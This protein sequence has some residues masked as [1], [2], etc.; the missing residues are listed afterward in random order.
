MTIFLVVIIPILSFLSNVIEKFIENIPAI[1]I[2]QSLH[3][4]IIMPVWIVDYVSGSKYLYY[5]Y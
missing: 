2:V 4:V 1:T 5:H 3:N